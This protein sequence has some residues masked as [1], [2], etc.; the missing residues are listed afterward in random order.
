MSYRHNFLVFSFLFIPKELKILKTNKLFSDSCKSLLTYV[1]FT[2]VVLSQNVPRGKD[3]ALHSH[4]E[5]IPLN[6][7]QLGHLK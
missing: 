5:N 6:L 1:K 3:T 2:D 4:F 7:K